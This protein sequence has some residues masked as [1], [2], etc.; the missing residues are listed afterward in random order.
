MTS[1]EICICEQLNL[2]KKEGSHCIDDTSEIFGA[3]GS[4]SKKNIPKRL[5]EYIFVGDILMSTLDYP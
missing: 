3:S 5:P 2:Q 4:T 1:Y